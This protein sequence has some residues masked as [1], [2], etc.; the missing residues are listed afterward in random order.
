[1]PTPGERKALLF[2]AGIAV[3]GGIVRVA[4]LRGEV[5]ALPSEDLAA[6]DRQLSA[7]DSASKVAKAT[8]SG[9]G[10]KRKQ[11]VRSTERAPPRAS[12][13][14]SLRDQATAGPVFPLQ[15]LD[16][17]RASA[18]EIE[19]LPGVG[20]ALAERIAT[21]R[22]SAGGLGGLDALDCVPGVGPALLRRLAPNVTFSA[23]RRPPCVLP[24]ARSATRRA[25]AP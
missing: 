24:K 21:W 10:G 13:E 14:S 19:A 23:S 1:M 2:L 4:G 17:D 5:R 6:L 16:L 12:V 9:G 3:L 15:P 8:R 11:K 22:D 18:M 25:R 7:S 20:P